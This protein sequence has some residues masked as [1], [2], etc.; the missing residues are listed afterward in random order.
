MPVIAIPKD[1]EFRKVTPTQQKSLEKIMS[2]SK[3][4]TLR[5]VAIPT[6]ALSTLAIV[7]GTAFLFREQ[8]KNFVEENIDDL[9]GAITEKIKDTAT[10]AGDIV[11]DTIVTI[12]GR[13]EPQ[14]PEFTPSG[15][16]P[17][18]RC[19]RWASDYVDTIKDDP[20]PSEIVLLA[21]AQKNIIKNMKREK[22]DRPS[23]IP[24][25]QWDDV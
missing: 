8:I 5:A 17:I 19:Q 1:I 16:G 10:G 12:V 3:N 24:Q 15:A 2:D 14:T 23:V 21:L 7:G 25:S 22:C 13:D 20:S 18:P 4:N 6:I 9:S 11:S